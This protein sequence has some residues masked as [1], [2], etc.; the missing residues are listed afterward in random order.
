MPPSTQAGNPAT[1]PVRLVDTSCLAKETNL[2]YKKKILY[3]HHYNWMMY[4]DRFSHFSFSKAI[5]SLC[6]GNSTC[7]YNSEQG[8]SEE[9]DIREDRLSVLRGTF[10][11]GDKDFRKP[12]KPCHV[13]IHWTALTEYSQMSTHVPGFQSFQSIFCIIFY[14]PN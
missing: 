9:E 10:V 7:M 8:H 13:G 3:Q 2:T 4:W 14:W 1:V 11:K 5:F 6:T 12:S